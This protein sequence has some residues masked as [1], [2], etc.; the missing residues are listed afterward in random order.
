MLLVLNTGSSSIK[1]G[2]FE[3]D[4]NR[5]L[6]GK[7]SSIDGDAYA[8]L[9]L[10]ETEKEI[11]A[12]DHAAALDALLDAFG[13]VTHIKAVAHRVVHGGADLTAPARLTEDV[14]ATI[15][16]CVPLAPLH[17]PPILTGIRAMQNLRPDLPQFASF[18]TAFHAGQ[19]AVQTAYAIPERWRAMGLRRYGF[20]GLSFAGM[21]E[22]F[23]EALPERLLALH[24]GAGCSLCAIHRG[25]SV[26]TTMGYSPVSGLTMATR[27]GDID[28]MAVLRM[29]EEVGLEE[30]SAILNTRSGLTG[31]AG[32]P[33]MRALLAAGTPEADFAVAHFVHTIIRE[34][35]GLIAAM[36]G[37]DAVAFTGG[38]GENSAAIRDR[39]MAG[40]SFLGDLAVHVIPAEEE[41]QIA[42]GAYRLLSAEAV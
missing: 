28:A 23:A 31:L 38:I 36:G 22:G 24:L 20:H 17:N 15:E 7:I 27:S 8:E 41:K 13:D 12:P 40:L 33:D 26:A 9:E 5:V 19:P 18:D 29:A 16:A 1:L 6:S 25:K 42:R 35:G 2:L 37:V 32:T 30:A 10:G 4:L 3:P 34:A 21:V 14:V 11:N 39:I